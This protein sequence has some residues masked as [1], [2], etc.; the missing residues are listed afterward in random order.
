M[1]FDF[2]SFAKGDDDGFGDSV[3][4]SVIPVND[5]EKKETDS[6]KQTTVDEATEANATIDVKVEPIQTTKDPAKG[7]QTYEEQTSPTILITQMDEDAPK[8][9]KTEVEMQNFAEIPDRDPGML[10]KP[11]SEKKYNYNNSFTSYLNP[12]QQIFRHDRYEGTVNLKSRDVRREFKSF[13]NLFASENAD[14]ELGMEESKPEG[15]FEGTKFGTWD[16]VFA[17]CLL[18]IFGVIMFL[19]LPKVIGYAGIGLGCGVIILSA[20]VVT[21]TTLSMSAIA[22]S[23]QVKEG[24]AYY[25]ISRSL[26]PEVGGAIGI[27]FSIGMSISVSLYVIGFVEVVSEIMGNDRVK[28]TGMLT[29]SYMNDLRVLGYILIVICL[30]MVLIGIGWIIKVQLIL[31]AL[32]VV[33]IITFFIGNFTIVSTEHGIGGLETWGTN[34]VKNL[35]PSFEGPHCTNNKNVQS[36]FFGILAE[37]FPAVT[38][39]MAGANI[40]GDLANP[41]ENIP[42]GTLWAIG[43]SITV[44]VIMAIFIGLAAEKEVI[45]GMPAGGSMRA[46]GCPLNKDGKV[47]ASEFGLLVDLNIMSK[48]AAHS[49]FIQAGV[50]AACFT[51]ALSSL[52]GAPRVLQKFADDNLISCCSFF[53]KTDST[54]NP[55]RGY[56]LSFFIACGCIAIGALDQISVLITMFFMMTYGLIN[57]SVFILELYRSPGWRPSFKMYNWFTALLG[58]ILCIALM[59]IIDWMYAIAANVIGGVI[60]MYISYADLDINWGTGMQSRLYYNALTSMLRLRKDGEHIKTFRPNFLI[61]TGA[62]DERPHLLYFGQTLGH[63][64]SLIVYCN[65]S[66][67]DY[68]QNINLYRQSHHGGYVQSGVTKGRSGEPLPTKPKVKGFFNSVIADTFQQG[69]QMALQLCGLGALKPNTM[70]MGFKEGWFGKKKEFSQKDEKSSEKPGP[71]TAAYVDMVIDSFKM[72]MAVMICRNLQRTIDWTRKSIFAKDDVIDLENGRH[73]IDIWWLMD[74]GGFSVLVPHMMA[75]N[76]FWK[77][78]DCHIRLMIPCSLLDVAEVKKLSDTFKDKLHL[79]IDVQPLSFDEDD[80]MDRPMGHTVMEHMNEV[81]DMNGHKR[82]DVTQRWMRIAEMMKQHSSEAKIIFVTL[83]FPRADEDPN[84]YM[85]RLEVISKIEKKRKETGQQYVPVVMLRG[86][87][88]ETYLTYYLE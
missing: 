66:I 34:F 52:V 23:G 53:A 55:I 33:C 36:N 74:D 28:G 7:E 77:A 21:L 76:D 54:G 49:A 8:G 83:P 71:T 2:D 62:P 46:D 43:I 1:S 25:L 85:S 61:H 51:S 48:M 80:D 3:Q 15:E 22:T 70:M 30:I 35:G 47:L 29:G 11:K 31:L 56:F 26:G 39:I 60:Y 73:T 10:G 13:T 79:N 82:K 16:G 67:G 72:G 17:S 38:G 63:S 86:A 65:V 27:L 12:N 84:E 9:M 87:P 78:K 5:A 19:R 40:S 42:K 24:G 50:F 81:S 59:F 4:D 57:W 45:L 58:A 18:C 69:N 88:G 6:N 32:L 20:V 68:R 37:F 44:Y 14:G 64:G 75:N 41:S